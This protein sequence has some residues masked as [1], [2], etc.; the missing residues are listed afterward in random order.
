MPPTFVETSN[1]VA[2]SPGETAEQVETQYATAESLKQKCPTGHRM[3]RVPPRPI[4]S[5]YAEDTPC[6]SPPDPQA[7]LGPCHPTRHGLKKR[8]NK[9]TESLESLALK[10]LMLE[11][12]EP[13]PA[14]SQCFSA[15]MLPPPSPPTCKTSMGFEGLDHEKRGCHWRGLVRFSS[16]EFTRLTAVHGR[17]LGGFTI[18]FDRHAPSQ[19]KLPPAQ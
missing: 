18:S 15:L 14:R 1:G 16:H 5:L 4:D 11:A 6:C 19:D 17:R 13:S 9:T 12:Q 8:S 2:F 3:L 10:G 7:P